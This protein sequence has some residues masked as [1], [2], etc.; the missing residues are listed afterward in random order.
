MKV[1]TYEKAYLLLGAATLIAC[2]AALAYSGLAMDIHLPTRVA[3]VDPARLQSTPPFDQPGVRQVDEDEYEAVI[4]GRAWAFVPAEIRVPANAEIT[5]V[6]TSADVIHGFNVA[7]TRIN[8]ML[9]P[10]Q[11]SQL[12]Y[13]FRR[14]GEYALICHEFCGLG[15]HLMSGRIIVE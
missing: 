13:T 2:L 11:V 15:H 3:E 8:M 6:S 1:H 9:I 14:P 5:F 10:G 12:K 4:I 7:G